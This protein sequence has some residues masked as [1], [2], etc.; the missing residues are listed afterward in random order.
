MKFIEKHPYL[1]IT[2]AIILACIVFQVPFGW[3]LLIL[4]GYGLIV[5]IVNLGT[6]VGWTGYLLDGFLRR[7]KFVH[8]LY[9]FAIQHNTRCVYAMLAYGMDLLKEGDYATAL[10]LFEKVLARDKVNPM[11]VKYAEQD[12]AIAYWKM[13]QLEKVIEVMEKMIEKYEYFTP[14][15]YTTLG[16][17]YIEAGDYEK[18]QECTDKALELSEA[19]GPAFDNLGQI[20]FR[21]GQYEEAEK[22]FSRALDMKDTMV[23]SK[24]HLGLIYEHWGNLE[25]AAEYF[26]AAHQSTITGMNTITREQVDAKY[27]EYWGDGVAEEDSSSTD[28]SDTEN[29]ETDDD[30]DDIETEE[31]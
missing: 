1:L 8:K 7:P 11:L 15:F 17:F 14:D 28:S 25:A 6:A 5:Y 13:G 29:I 22:Y 23:D 18:A 2:A 21:Q 10:D 31:R 26:A 16:Y 4:L 19:H 27:N 30:P 9:R 3:S 20:A 24:Y 12:L